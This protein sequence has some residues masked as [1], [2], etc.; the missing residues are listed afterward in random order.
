MPPAVL[1]SEK[2]IRRSED[3]FRRPPDVLLRSMAGA[4]LQPASLQEIRE[5]LRLALQGIEH[6]MQHNYAK[7]VEVFPPARDLFERLGFEEEVALCL[8]CEG[9]SL[10]NLGQWEEAAERLV[11]PTQHRGILGDD[12]YTDLLAYLGIALHNASRHGE[13]VETLRNARELL[14]PLPAT[15]SPASPLG[16]L[17]AASL[18]ALGQATDAVAVYEQLN[19]PPPNAAPVEKQTFYQGWARSVMAAGVV[20]AQ[21]ARLSEMESMAHKL[22]A[23]K[24]EA[25]QQG[26]DEVEKELQELK[27][28]AQHDTTLE[29]AIE[30]FMLLVRLLS[31][32]DPWEAW[33]ALS[34]EV[35]KRWP[36]GVSAVDAVREQR[37]W[38]QISPSTR[39]YGFQ[40]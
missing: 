18:V 32:E 30:E 9:A 16:V 25:Q 26:T 36:E 19:P 22:I 40:P 2:L 13:A 33:D 31:I 8:F 23:L 5:A 6:F 15:K 10:V 7:A 12:L 3:A 14:R 35:S 20:A 28:A 11:Q 38:W 1:G 29:V 37:R 27:A 4:A 34:E 39:L 24:D 21:E 17:E